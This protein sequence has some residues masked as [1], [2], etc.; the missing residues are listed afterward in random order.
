MILRCFICARESSMSFNL[1]SVITTLEIMTATLQFSVQDV[2]A[3][4]E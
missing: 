1:Q 2:G 3:M 4:Y